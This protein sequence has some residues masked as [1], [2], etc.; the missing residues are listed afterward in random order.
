MHICHYVNVYISP[1]TLIFENFR[2]G[3]TPGT[4]F[5]ESAPAFPQRKP[6]VCIPKITRMQQGTAFSAVLF[7]CD[8]TDWPTS[9]FYRG[10]RSTLFFCRGRIEIK[11][12]FSWLL[13]NNL[14][15]VEML[16]EIQK[17]RLTPRLF[18]FKQHFSTSEVFSATNTITRALFLKYTTL[19][20]NVLWDSE[21]L[22][23]QC[24]KIRTSKSY[25]LQIQSRVI[26]FNYKCISI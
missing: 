6:I 9:F 16:F 24:E 3:R 19:R 20:H 14:L 11:H 21:V 25:Q 10:K 1:K 2:G 13:Q 17:P 15:G 12:L 18:Y 23:A 7:K 8:V 22:L 5:L 4:P 26:I